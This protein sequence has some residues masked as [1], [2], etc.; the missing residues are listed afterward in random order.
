M[1]WTSPHCAQTEKWMIGTW[2]VDESTWKMT[3]QRRKD[4]MLQRCL[5]IYLIWILKSFSTFMKENSK[6]EENIQRGTAS[7]MIFERV[8]QS[9]EIGKRM[10]PLQRK[11]ARFWMK[12]QWVF[13]KNMFGFKFDLCTLMSPIYF[14]IMNPRNFT[15]TGIRKYWIR[16][17][18]I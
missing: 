9:F 6:R 8:R 1:N 11:C 16:L 4:K 15:Y 10:Q 13:H 18:M 12:I 5:S 17:K 7:S 14:S 2:T 3:Q